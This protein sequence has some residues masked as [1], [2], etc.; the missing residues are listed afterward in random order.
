VV[1]LQA[2]AY[3]VC[4]LAGYHAWG[5]NRHPRFTR[6]VWWAGAPRWSLHTLWRGY[7]QAF[8]RSPLR[9][10]TRATARGAWAEMQTWL[11][12]MDALAATTQAA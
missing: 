10:P 3:A 6:G 7:Q 9:H 12:Q 5:Y 11:H 8:G 4:V 2:W 1:H